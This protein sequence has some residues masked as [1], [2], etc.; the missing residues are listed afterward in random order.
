MDEFESVVTKLTVNKA[1][2]LK[3]YPLLKIEDLF[4]QLSGGPWFTKLN[5]RDAYFRRKNL[6]KNQDT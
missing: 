2:E 5:L 3:Q 6:M 4:A 1:T